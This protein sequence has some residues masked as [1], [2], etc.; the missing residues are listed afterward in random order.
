M[1]YTYQDTELKTESSS[2]NN[3]L[4]SMSF[5]FLIF[6]MTVVPHGFHVLIDCESNS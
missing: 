5:S 4:I 2:L 6:E 3:S 1:Y